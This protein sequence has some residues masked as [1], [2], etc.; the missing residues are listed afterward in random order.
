MLQE[1][2]LCPEMML[3]GLHWTLRF[4][5]SIQGEAAEYRGLGVNRNRLGNWHI[6]N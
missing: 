2:L 6:D 3:W 5:E 1:L 4:F